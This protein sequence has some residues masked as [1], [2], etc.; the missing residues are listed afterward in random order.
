MSN[1]DT[2]GFSLRSPANSEISGSGSSSWIVVKSQTMKINN[3]C[4]SS[5]LQGV[6]KLRCLATSPRV[7]FMF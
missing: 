5:L 6:A 1:D 7:V 2:G 4:G 3:P